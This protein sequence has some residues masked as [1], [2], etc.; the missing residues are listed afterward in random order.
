VHF[1]ELSVYF[2]HSRGYFLLSYFTKGKINDSD[3]SFALILS[4]LE[5]FDRLLL[6]VSPA[7]AGSRKRESQNE[8]WQSSFKLLFAFKFLYI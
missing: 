1:T 3:K 2:T 4:F 8:S 5:R 6:S 7:V